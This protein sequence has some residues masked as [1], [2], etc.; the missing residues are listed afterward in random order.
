MHYITDESLLFTEPM[1][2]E[3][4]DML[5]LNVDPLYQF[6]GSVTIPESIQQPRTKPGSLERRLTAHFSTV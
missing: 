3:I 2:S 5:K 1:E 6:I 4:E